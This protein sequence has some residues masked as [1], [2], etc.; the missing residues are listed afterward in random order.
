MRIVT[1]GGVLGLSFESE[2]VLSFGGLLAVCVLYCV[3]LG[4]LGVEA[5]I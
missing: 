2:L 5:E 4:L 1:T 3:E